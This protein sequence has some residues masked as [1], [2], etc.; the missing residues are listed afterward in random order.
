MGLCYEC[1][2]HCEPQECQS[3]GGTGKVE[4]LADENGLR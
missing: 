4:I 2:D 3:C 1:H